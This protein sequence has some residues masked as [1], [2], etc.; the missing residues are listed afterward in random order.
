M[1]PFTVLVLSTNGQDLF[2]ELRISYIVSKEPVKQD[3]NSYTRDVRKLAPGPML[4]TQIGNIC[5]HL[6]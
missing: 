1:P 6:A 2:L 3:K 5:A 4:L